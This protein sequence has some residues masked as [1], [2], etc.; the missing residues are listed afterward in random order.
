[1]PD[2][3]SLVSTLWLASSLALLVSVLFAPVRASGFGTVASISSSLQHSFDLAPGQPP[4]HL[5]GAVDADALVQVSAL[6]FENEEQDRVDAP[7]EP[8][9]GLR[10]ARS[11]RK[12][13][14]CR[15]IAPCSIPSL[16]PL[17]C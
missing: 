6:P 10:I 17:R 7:D 16:Y 12:V 11:F 1:M 9:V 5:D 3:R 15:L 14:D 13:T 4:T 8:Q 2:R